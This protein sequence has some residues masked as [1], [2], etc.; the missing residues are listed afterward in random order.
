MSADT[1]AAIPVDQGLDLRHL[2]QMT[3]DVGLLEHALGAI[4]R[5]EHGYCVD[6][7]ARAAVLLC[8]EPNPSAAVVRLA[9]QYTVFLIRAQGPD[10]DFHNRLGYNGYW[11]DQPGDGD[12]WGR[13]L[14]GLGTAAAY[15][16]DPWLRDD[17]L[18]CFVHGARVRPVHLRAMAFAA[19]G[20]VQVLAAYP[21]HRVARDLLADAVAAIGPDGTD[22]AWPWPQKRL[23]YANA[24]LPE[25]L[26]GGG[27]L[28]GDK[29]LMERGLRLLDWLLEAESSQGHLSPAPVGGRSAGD[30]RPG[31]DQ[32]PIEVAALA[33]ACASALAATGDPR[34]AQGIRLAAAWFEGDNDARTVMRDP[35]TGGGYDG[36]TPVGPNENQGAESTLALLST[37]QQ[38]RRLQMDHP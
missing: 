7:A 28:L 26:I 2:Q 4:A 6:D 17:A 25:V 36:L 33:D 12:W 30:E 13:A 8:R 32:Q 24:V 38:H 5:L 37:L 31:F 14:W 21:A 11:Q 9:A 16:P 23:H 35:D 18:A 3:D 22:R 1:V 29:P 20:A 19:L 10:G 27:R 15:G 34:W